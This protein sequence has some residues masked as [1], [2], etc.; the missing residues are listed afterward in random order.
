[1]PALT[2]YMNNS[3]LEQEITDLIKEQFYCMRNN[4]TME[5]SWFTILI[6]KCIKKLKHTA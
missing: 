4:L 2:I 6:E 3:K 1:M 5:Y